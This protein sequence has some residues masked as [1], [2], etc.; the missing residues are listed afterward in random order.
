MAMTKVKGLQMWCQRRVEGYRDVNVVDMT[1]SW[2]SGLAF[3]A[4]IHK[5]RP[6]LIDYDS[7]SKENIFENNDLAF[8]V[9][10]RELGI[11]ALLE[12]QDMVDI[13][14]PD[15]L[16]VVTYVSQY[17]NFFKDAPQI[18]GPGV[19]AKQTS[20]SSHKRSPAVQ[21]VTGPEIKRFAPANDRNVESAASKKSDD[22]KKTSTL[23]DKC[24]ICNNKVYLLERQIENGK[25][26]HRSC[27]RHS[28]LSPT[29][30]VFKS[31]LTSPSD[32]FASKAKVRKTDENPSWVKSNGLK[33][34]EPS[35]NSKS[36]PS[37]SL[38][39]SDA[40][41]QPTAAAGSS[42]SKPDPLLERLKSRM[43]VDKKESD[44]PKYKQ[45]RPLIL[46]TAAKEP[47]DS[48]KAE[49]PTP[50]F[51][52]KKF[53]KHE[54]GFLSKNKESNT[55]AEESKPKETKS[56]FLSSKT[57]PS[58]PTETS[59]KAAFPVP[60]SRN[61]GLKETT[62][63]EKMDTS[64]PFGAKLKHVSPTPVK[65]TFDK[66][67]DKSHKPDQVK[68]K[69]PLF[70]KKLL[71]S[72]DK[73]HAKD[74]V[75][76]PDSPPPPL[77]T[78]QPPL[79]SPQSTPHIQRLLHPSPHPCP[80][81]PIN[82]LTVQST[83]PPLPPP[84]PPNTNKVGILKTTTTTNAPKS[85]TTNVLKG[86]TTTAVSVTTSTSVAPLKP[87]RLYGA[88]GRSESPMDVDEALHK[89]SHPRPGSE[90]VAVLVS[91]TEKNPVQEKRVLGG[92]L[93]SLANV[94]QSKTDDV[95]SPTDKSSHNMPSVAKSTTELRTETTSNRPKS[96]SAL[97][98]SKVELSVAKTKVV[99]DVSKKKETARDKKSKS[100]FSFVSDKIGIFKKDDKKESD[101]IILKG[102]QTS[103]VTDSS[104]SKTSAISSG[105]NLTTGAEKVKSKDTSKSKQEESVPSWKKDTGLKD[106]K[107][108]GNNLLLD[109]NV[110]SKNSDNIRSWKTTDHSKTRGSDLLQD[111]KSEQKSKLEASDQVPAW[112]QRMQ[113]KGQH[114]SDQLLDS[115]TTHKS[116][117]VADDDT[118]QWMK[119]LEK[120][121]AEKARP[122]SV[123]VLL[124]ESASKKQ[125]KSDQ[126][127]LRLKPKDE[128]GS[129]GVKER[130]KS[131]S[132]LDDSTEK[133]SWQLEAQRRLA[134][135]KQAF[136]DPEKGKAVNS[137]SADSKPAQ[138]APQKKPRTSNLIGDTP[139]RPPRLKISP[140][141]ASPPP[142]PK[143][144]V[145]Q[146]KKISIGPGFEL[147][148]ME[149]NKEP[150][151]PVKTPPQ[152][153]P[154]PKGSPSKTVSPGRMSPAIIQRQLDDIDKK[155][156]N[157]E[158]RGRDLEDSIRNVDT[159][160]EEDDMM[161]EWFKL[162]NSKNELVRKEADL[163]YISKQ[164]DL[165][166]EQEDID[167]MLNFL[168]AIPEL[169]K[170][171]SQKK[172]V[173]DLIEKKLD[174]VNRRSSIVDCIDEDRIRY[175]E[176]DKDIAIM[177]EAKVRRSRQRHMRQGYVQGWIQRWW[178]FVRAHICRQWI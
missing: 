100:P 161:I 66:K 45:N 57:E 151:S 13:R 63:V 41:S 50:T 125:G 110:P 21:P 24:V 101:S 167:E 140:K 163:I 61:L 123:D 174:I 73:S 153:P 166:D 5:F 4:L 64:E 76:T 103:K 97:P 9:A 34:V 92:L 169:E 105:V 32:D 36:D 85:T 89:A 48:K 116:E 91:P 146:L 111:S 10:E 35:Q 171:K 70:G 102:E 157:L 121:K 86:T 30:K 142:S 176:E 170:T 3:C 18:G 107:S 126:V 25:L 54:F 99:A 16:S 122:K 162:I 65:K 31:S 43:E 115:N 119:A 141:A 93:A 139:I 8:E 38:F 2:K 94:R 81:P 29:A 6:D 59:S 67:N 133:P 117:P 109:S 172:R 158:M 88:D 127:E 178:A 37:K 165:E 90:P 42:S 75:T 156:N 118:P 159:T 20:S 60:K 28:E 22:T 113:D 44:V 79:H 129:P 17:Y 58:K 47:D 128:Q 106:Q 55:K 164:Q 53:D 46:Q 33:H 136:I 120:R 52:A 14:V 83:Y 7:L 78:S 69:S 77:P 72:N 144:P 12:A 114:K 95:T 82:Q 160:E 80:H 23:G 11:P 51:N 87:P 15:K 27:F 74:K 108:N 39:S 98:K 168:V 124:E 138:T 112:K 62:K 175:E 145:R 132:I 150:P 104:S 143:A 152:R 135:N 173:D 137:D 84:P 130:A 26:Y 68:H 71:L 148:S 154:A 131:A 134:H 1:K 40:R 155:L 19:T 177:L 149:E 96:E 49:P 147:N 56:G